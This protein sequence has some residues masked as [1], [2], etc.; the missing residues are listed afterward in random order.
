MYLE[1]FG[2]QEKPFSTSPDPRY[3]YLSGQHKEALAK[4][5]YAASQKLGLCTVYGEIGVG[6]TSIARRLWQKFQDENGFVTAMLPHPN[7][8]TENQLLKAILQE[9]R[10]T[11]G[12]RRSKFDLMNALNEFLVEQWQQGKT[13]VLI[14]D[15]AQALKPPL[16][17]LLREILNFETNTEKLLQIVLFGQTELQDRL[18]RKPS[19]KSR[20]A[21]YGTLSPLSRIETEAMIDYRYKVAGGQEHPFEP[22]AV[23]LIYRLSKGTPR[24]ICVLSDNSLLKALLEE[25]RRVSPRV[26]EI[27]GREIGSL[28]PEAKPEAKVG[29]PKKS[30]VKEK[31]TASAVTS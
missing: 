18:A 28:E 3:L 10:V 14:I 31:E 15:E 12:A 1:H 17:E 29:R 20:V 2:L 26:V 13:T 7:Y 30:E 4:V 27:V 8:P 6:K 22:G 24:A 9:F 19:I 23:D 5:E 25:S 21:V 16:L 11:K